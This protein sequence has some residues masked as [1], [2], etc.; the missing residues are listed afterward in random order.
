MLYNKSVL[1]RKGRGRGGSPATHKEEFM[2]RKVLLTLLVLVMT[3]CC[4]ATLV[5]C[6]DDPVP[7]DKK[8][9]VYLGDSIAEGILGASPLG[10]RQEYAYANVLGRRND[11]VYYNHSV[12]GHLTKDLLAILQ[13]ELDYDGARAL[14]LHV[15]EADVIHI[16]IL[17]NDVLQDRKDGAFKSDPVTMHNI[18]L[19]AAKGE[20]TSIDRV[21]NGYT[22]G[23]VT[24]V[25][26]VENIKGIVDALKSLN[27]DALIIFQS[28]YN[29]I[30]DVD[31]PLIKQETRDALTE[32]G[33]KIT[34]DSL[35]DLGDLLI[36]RLNSALT[37][38]LAT[39]GYED[40][41]V[42]ADGHAAF[43]EVYNADRSRAE[44]L[45][46]PDGI[47]PSNEGHAVLA[48]L[49]QGILE[50]KGLAKA[51]SAL[52]GYK[53]MRKNVLA[54]YFAEQTDVAAASAEIDAAATCAEVTEIFFDATQGL[55][56]D[57]TDIDYSYAE[58]TDIVTVSEDVFYE[59]D[60]D[61]I[62][63]GLLE[64]EGLDDILNVIERLLPGG[65][66]NS[67]L[68]TDTTG[69]TL[70]ADGTM[71]IRLEL[72]EVIL[73]TFGSL[74]EEGLQGIVDFMGQFGM[75]VDPN[76]IEKLKEGML[77]FANTYLEPIVPGFVPE[78]GTSIADNILNAFALAESSLGLK[79]V[80]DDPAEREEFLKT[81]ASV[82]FEG[83]VDAP[84]VIPDGF[85]LVVESEYTLGGVTY[86]DGTYYPGVYLIPSDPD[87]RSYLVFSEYSGTDGG[88]RLNLKV[89]FLKLDLWLTQRA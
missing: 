51:S 55:K 89:D 76:F 28:V 33:F 62:S 8:E 19:E 80:C 26:S 70:R 12:S 24:T 27:P 2:K 45:I 1:S 35:H 7:S 21:L 88:S 85:A 17:G 36:K 23:D 84:I 75:T 64:G 54:D 63:L 81:L 16:S 22:A 37:T 42:I 56:A 44:R 52:A 82:L 71:E 49:T 43:N 57:Y 5:A 78:D 39:E 30:M 3:A 74:L 61:N 13:N 41:F 31:T 69:V 58:R 40:S 77:G 67:L 65:I 18:I 15:S 68:N 50:D 73:T 79:V 53:V 38:V 66:W 29:P 6:N 25:G 4:V 83:N 47:H 32:E 10:L 14:L 60:T 9:I 48:D 46:Y 72:G 59:I 34:L 87:T 20:Y 86:P 11:Y